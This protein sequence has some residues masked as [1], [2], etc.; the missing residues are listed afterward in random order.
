MLFFHT[1]CILSLCAFC[2]KTSPSLLSFSFSPSPLHAC[3]HTR[4]QTHARAHIPSICVFILQSFPDNS[5][6]N[7]LLHVEN[8]LTFK[9]KSSFAKFSPYV[10]T[11][12]VL[13]L[14]AVYKQEAYHSVWHNF[15]N[16]F[17]S[18]IRAEF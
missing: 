18:C 3:T 7:V 8:L 14:I 6:T 11:H 17:V 15:K 10:Q 2:E 1:P 5:F 9:I 4:T 16:T 13:A 12:K